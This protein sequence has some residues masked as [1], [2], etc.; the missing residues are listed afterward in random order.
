MHTGTR[1]ALAV[2]M[3][4]VPRVRSAAI[5]VTRNEGR[6]FSDKQV[7]LMKTFAD[8]AVIAIENVRLFQECGRRNAELREALEH[9]TAT[10][11]VLGII[12]RSPNRRAAGLNAIVESAARVCGVDDVAAAIRR[13]VN[14]MVRG[15]ILV[16]YLLSASEIS[17]DEPTLALDGTTG[18][19][20]FPMF[21]SRTI[22]KLVDS[23]GGNA[24]APCWSFPFVSMGNSLERWPHVARRCAPSPG[25]SSS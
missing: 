8:E 17:I 6:P 3:L 18:A 22:L 10:A 13:R 12:S 7:A 15:P 9:Q 20:T 11:E 2:P 4:R 5:T 25:S 24:G 14:N 1:A 23:S 19:S 21:V 16:R